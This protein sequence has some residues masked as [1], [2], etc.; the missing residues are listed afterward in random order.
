MDE[1]TSLY[2]GTHVPV[3]NMNSFHGTVSSCENCEFNGLDFVGGKSKQPFGRLHL[4]LEVGL[5]SHH[6]L[7]TMGDI[8]VGV[9]VGVYTGVNTNFEISHVI[10]IKIYMNVIFL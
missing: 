1:V 9:S 2:D 3:E 6:Q 10:G 8:K 4:G 7:C 5:D